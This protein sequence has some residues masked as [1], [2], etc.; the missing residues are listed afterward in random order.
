[1]SFIIKGLAKLQ[2]EKLVGN[3]HLLGEPTNNNLERMYHSLVHDLFRIINKDR[4]D[5]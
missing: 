3:F 2:S 1:M 5:E 4:L